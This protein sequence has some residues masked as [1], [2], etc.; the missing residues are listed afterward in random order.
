MNL[1]ALYPHR[2]TR[3]GRWGARRL[4][5][6][7]EWRLSEFVDI[8]CCLQLKSIQLQA[9]F[10]VFHIGDEENGYRIR[11]LWIRSV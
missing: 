3:R 2:C 6:F 1:A 9:I 7:V 10:I 8:I 4:A 11:P 5:G